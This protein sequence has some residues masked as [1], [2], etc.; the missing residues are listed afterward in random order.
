MEE[1][2][3]LKL[4]NMKLTMHQDQDKT[5][6]RDRINSIIEVIVKVKAII[7]R[8]IKKVEEKINVTTNQKPRPK[9]VEES[10]QAGGDD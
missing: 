3:N 4:T 8:K 5:V 2:K 1:M 9:E 6:Q 10:H 7:T